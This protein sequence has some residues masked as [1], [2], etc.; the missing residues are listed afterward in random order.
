MGMK[1]D[2]LP[3]S[4]I[5]RVARSHGAQSV[6]VFGSRARGDARP[7]SDLGLLVTMD[8]ELLDL[9]A[10]KQDLEELLQVTV[11]VVTGRSVSPYLRD[12]V[13]AEARSFRMTLRTQLAHLHHIRDALGSVREY[14]RGGRSDFFCVEDGSRCRASRTWRSSARRRKR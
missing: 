14:T 9:I 10:I 3:V 1:S 6:R 13:F 8:P 7:N 12:R 4:D 5:L 11:D 2:A